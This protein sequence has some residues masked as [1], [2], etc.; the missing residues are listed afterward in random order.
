[1]GPEPRLEELGTWQRHERESIQKEG[2]ALQK[3]EFPSGLL[4]DC[5]ADE[6]LR[7]LKPRVFG[8]HRGVRDEDGDVV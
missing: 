8:A 2:T 4:G 1:M 7:R 5:G 6:K 3:H